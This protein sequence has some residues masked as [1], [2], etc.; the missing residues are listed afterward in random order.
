MIVRAPPAAPRVIGI[1]DVTCAAAVEP[2]ATR[3]EPAA[4]ASESARA[5][6]RIVSSS[7]VVPLTSI[8]R[9][10]PGRAPAIR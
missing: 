1:Q 3:H 7:G 9:R 10:A 4:I 2:A 5:A 8:C 6:L